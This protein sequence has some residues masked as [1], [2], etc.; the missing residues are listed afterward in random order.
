M[1]ISLFA[2]N[3]GFLDDV[4]VS[5]VVDFEGAMQ[6]YMKSEQADLLARINETGDYNAEIES[7]MRA[8]LE[9]FK[10]SSTW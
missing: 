8:A 4:A 9:S 5:K 3:Q 1:A 2:A 6:S 10:A 7:A